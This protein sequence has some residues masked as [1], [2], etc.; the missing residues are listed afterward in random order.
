MAETIL[1]AGLLALEDF[2]S[3][4]PQ[5]RVV[6]AP[7]G[8]GKSSY[9]FALIKAVIDAVDGASAVFL[10]ET[11]DQC[12]DT[13]RELVKL[14]GP[15]DLAVWTTSHDKR[16]TLEDV[17]AEDG[18]RPSAQF[19]VDDL[20][21]H[22]VVVVTH[23]FYRGPRGS[24][25]RLYGGNHRILTIVDE[26][27]KEVSIYDVDQGDVLKA[28][29]W[30]V[31][32]YGYDSRAVEAFKGLHDYLNGAWESEGNK[33]F[34]SLQW[35]CS[36]WFL[37]HQAYGVLIKSSDSIPGQVIGFAQALSEGY[38]FMS[39]FERGAK[40][41]RFVGY[42]MDLPVFPGTVLLDATSNIDGVSELVSWRIAVSSPQVSYENLTITHITPP[43]DVVEPGERITEIVRHSERAKAYASWIR[44]TVVR[45]TSPG[46]KVLV[47]VH[48]AM[49]EGNHLPKQDSLGEDAYDLDGRRVALINWGY[50]IGSNR[51]KTATSVFLFGEFHLPKRITMGQ[52]LALLDQPVTE[53]GLS[54][55]QSPNSVDDDL[56]RLQHGHLLRWEKQL[57]MRG[58]A[59][60]IT[61]HGTCG[62]QRL[63]ICSE[64]KRL[65]PNVN[66]LFPDAVFVVE[67][68]V[69][70]TGNGTEALARILLSSADRKSI[71]NWDIQKEAG[72]DVG[73]HSGRLLQN[74]L[75]QEAM[76][77]RGW[78]YM[79][80]GGRGNRSRFERV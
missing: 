39:R 62:E 73:K 76:K 28:R 61:P 22:R 63:F 31:G 21:S 78:V 80:G 12:E 51:W 45:N 34:R 26:R 47:V 75:V 29:D 49:L 48:K 19:L 35:S 30:A 25:A 55:L 38:A 8:S 60:N 42:K 54:K 74:P 1:N 68:P 44:E 16:R 50:G 56:L 71:S 32:Q 5:Y 24:L 41:G 15:H 2:A 4:I 72:V 46:E 10:C 14:L 43:L 69:E 13:Y 36:S 27:P 64:F 20:D 59:R 7:T 58:N 6:S 11:V 37:S 3:G 40:G 9:A 53:Y 17:E 18:F 57:A 77:A 79:P 23:A 67:E 33:S 52:M 70:R 66:K 65:F